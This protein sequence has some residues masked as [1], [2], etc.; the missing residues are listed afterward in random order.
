MKD[1]GEARGI[2]H[3]KYIP[4]TRNGQSLGPW[5]LACLVTDGEVASIG[6]RDICLPTFRNGT[7]IR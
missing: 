6:N 3:Y 4:D 5:V 7:A 1:G 2:M